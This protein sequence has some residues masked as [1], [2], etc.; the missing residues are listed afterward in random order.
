MACTIIDPATV[1]LNGSSYAYGGAIS[2]VSLNFGGLAQSIRASVTLVQSST[3]ST[4]SK[5][6]DFD[7]KIMGANM[8]MKVGGYSFSNSATQATSLT[9]NLYD[10]SNEFLDQDFI[11][12]K[13]EFPTDVNFA[14]VQVLGRKYGTFP[15]DL[16]VLAGILAP[17]SDTRWGD[18]RN[19][20]EDVQAAYNA[21]PFTMNLSNSDVD[22]HVHTAAGKTLWYSN[23][24]PNDGTTL[25]EALGHL[26]D[27]SLP[28]G[29]F[30]FQG[31]YRDVIVQLCN[32]A[33]WMAY[34]DPVK[35]KVKIASSFNTAN[36]FQKLR[37]IS[38]QCECISSSNSSDFTTAMSKGAVGTFTSN[39]PGESQNSQ[40]GKMSRYYKARLLDPTFHYIKCKDRIAGKQFEELDFENADVQKA[41]AASQNPDI[42]KAYVVQT[43]LKAHK[44]I[45][46]PATL[47]LKNI[48]LA[49]EDNQRDQL[50]IGWDQ[51]SPDYRV[52]SYTENEL[53][54]NYY[55][56]DQV[57]STA[58]A[59]CKGAIWSIMYRDEKSMAAKELNLWGKRANEKAH[60]SP[61]VS[62]LGEFDQANQTVTFKEGIIFAKE[63]LALTG[64]LGT[65]STVISP[66]GN[67]AEV[68]S[69]GLLL[70]LKALSNFVK[71]FY[72]M[73]EGSGLRTLRDVD[74]IDY[75]Y[76]ISSD[77]ALPGMNL[78]PSQGEL[79]A[80]PPYASVA[81]CGVPELAELAIACSLMYTNSN[82]C[83]TDI[84]EN[85]AV[86]DF[87]RAL[88][89]NKLKELYLN[90]ADFRKADSIWDLEDIE[91]GIE[92]V[93]NM[94]LCKVDDPLK[95][96]SF[97]TPTNVNCEM[98]G[99]LGTQTVQ[100]KVEEIAAKLIPL[101]PSN[102]QT[103]I[104]V[105]A[106]AGGE[107]R[108]IWSTAFGTGTY[109]LW[110]ITT[111]DIG[112]EIP[113]WKPPH[114]PDRLK[115]WYDVEGSMG[116]LKK[117]PG[118]FFLTGAKIPTKD[119]K[120]VWKGQIDYG[121]S[122][123][124]ADIG[125][126]NKIFQ[127]FAASAAD[128]G[129]PYSFQNQKLMATALANKIS[130]ASW[131]DS[132]SATSQ[133]VTVLLGKQTA[134]INLPSFEDGLES[135]SIQNS[136][137]KLEIQITVGNSLERQAKKTMLE[138]MAK[139]AHI[140]HVFGSSIPD[141]FTGGA[142]PRLVALAKGIAR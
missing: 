93:Y 115:I 58:A 20:F 37:T 108:E 133:S 61:P 109:S 66:D 21:N 69:D 98:M 137:G 74:G 62:V 34:W 42:Y 90:P 135:L 141:T 32:T 84:T 96:D 99:V 107:N 46:W 106:G 50:P 60:D 54:K 134:N 111:A 12:L 3:F 82:T 121:V 68:K 77:S 118:Q 59:P 16:L 48:D 100:N 44:D 67:V 102:S 101:N 83:V 129:S 125:L 5:G 110:G 71:R 80:V 29:S 142:S 23:Y 27:G 64:I 15:N 138:L 95:E 56:N 65:K 81:A 43:M 45:K 76:Y 19:Y 72:V 36:G 92:P 131:T 11:A 79:H 47:A 52:E 38:T 113:E 49:G 39:Y 140:Q 63:D 117:G 7:L 17:N 24:D 30:D 116:T 85:L 35:N 14:N 91:N 104:A 9:L 33:G 94:F 73:R 87:I 26:L 18:L 127:K 114:K 112:A 75:G 124:A 88:D 10:K 130:N 6:D 40:G 136:N 103:N 78:K 123:N 122:V 97:P 57:P 51:S 89:Q 8:K 132:A 25:K 139:S 86:I 31:S 4:P 41:I 55:E 2:S 70:Y 53:L 119:K 126:G 105:K 1:S 28:D 120:N 128:E 13:E 22:Y